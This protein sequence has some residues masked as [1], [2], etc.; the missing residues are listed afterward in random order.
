M[1]FLDGAMAHVEPFE[2]Q[3]FDVELRQPL[4]LR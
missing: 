4:V 2:Y 1:I 3:L